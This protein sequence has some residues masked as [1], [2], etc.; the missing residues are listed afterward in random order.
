MSSLLPAPAELAVFLTAATALGLTPGPDMLLVVNRALSLGFRQ[1]MVT[2]AGILAGC[3][4]HTLAA[5]FGLSVVLI[6]LSYDYDAVRF[7][8]VAYLAFLGW[9]MIRQGRGIELAGGAA[10]SIRRR[11]LF[12]QALLTNLLNPKVALF[13]LAFLPQFVPPDAEQPALRIVILGALFF[14]IGLAIMTVAAAL[15]GRIRHWALAHPRALRG[16]SVLTG[17][18]LLVFATGLAVSG[19]PADS[20]E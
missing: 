5:A 6:K 10:S 17:L 12:T 7:A 4:L 14:G 11:R 16:Q 18:L 13:V 8:G 3:S 9:Q 1:G 15:A 20:G 2:M 19:R